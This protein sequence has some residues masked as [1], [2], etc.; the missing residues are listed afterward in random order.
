M[1]RYGSR[2][3]FPATPAEWLS[4]ETAK[5]EEKVRLVNRSRAPPQIESRERNGGGFEV[6]RGERPHSV[7]LEFWG[8]SSWKN[9][10]CPRE[11]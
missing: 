10:S 8:K 2:R 6:N 3:D 1:P 5:Y 11:I 4:G 7:D 9:G